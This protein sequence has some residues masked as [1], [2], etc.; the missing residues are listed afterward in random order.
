MAI[1]ESRSELGKQREK[2]EV[3]G[4]LVQIVEV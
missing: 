2:R 4:S 3:A 1:H